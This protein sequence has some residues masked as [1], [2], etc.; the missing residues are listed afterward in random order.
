MNHPIPTS[1]QEMMALRQQ[2][3]T[4]DLVV[5]A[6]AGVVKIARSRQQ[7]LED[8]KAEVLADDSLLNREQRVW[9][10]ELVTHAWQSLP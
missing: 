9:L 3:V 10:S 1:P 4:D 5:T 7:S 2:P 6:L 8:L